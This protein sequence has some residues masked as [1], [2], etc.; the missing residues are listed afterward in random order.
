MSLQ[1]R[2]DKVLSSN[3]SKQAARSKKT[4][5]FSKLDVET[6]KKELNQRKVPLPCS[7]KDPSK[8]PTKKELQATLSK[9]MC[10]NH[11]VPALIV[12]HPTQPLS[13]HN[14]E[15]YEVLPVEPLHV[16][17][18][19]VKNLLDEIPHHPYK[20]GLY[21]DCIIQMYS[22]ESSNTFQKIIDL[23]SQT[24]QNEFMNCFW[25]VYEL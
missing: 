17:K 7:A 8:E 6:I 14:L 13:N 25:I 3:T 11:R 24:I 21:L 20:R 18:R 16:I 10:G 2:I 23:I 5:Y 22:T 15:S 19:H 4:N 12:N 1:D 9:T